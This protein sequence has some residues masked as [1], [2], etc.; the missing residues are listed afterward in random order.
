MR[1][2]TQRLA[3]FGARTFSTVIATSMARVYTEINFVGISIGILIEINFEF[4]RNY[5]SILSKVIGVSISTVG[6]EIPVRN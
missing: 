6:I 4:R 5:W 1:C 2:D 3:A